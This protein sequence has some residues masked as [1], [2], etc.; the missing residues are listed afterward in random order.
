MVSGDNPDAPPTILNLIYI[1][2]RTFTDLKSE[3]VQLRESVDR[4]RVSN[5]DLNLEILELTS[6]V[7]DLVAAQRPILASQRSRPTPEETPTLIEAQP[8]Q[9]EDRELQV[10]DC[11]RFT[12][13]Q[14]FGVEGT[15]HSFTNQ[16]VRITIEGQRRPVIRSKNNLVRI[17]TSQN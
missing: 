2:E 6:T 7:Q 3:V 10:G 13:R 12:S 15:V 8:V 4:L 14:Q 17:P 16:C 11:V 1:L 5:R 9:N